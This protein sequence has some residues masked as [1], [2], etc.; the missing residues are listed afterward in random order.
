MT[1]PHPLAG[2]ARD[3][4]VP[5]TMSSVH[6]QTPPMF[7]AVKI[8][9]ERLM[10]AAREGREV[11]RPARPV[12]VYDF[13]VWRDAADA[14]DARYSIA[15][16]KGTYVRSLVHDLVRAPGARLH[17]VAHHA[18]LLLLGSMQL[19]GSCTTWPAGLTHWTECVGVCII[20]CICC[21]AK[22]SG[23]ARTSESCEERAV[24]TSM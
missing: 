16:S 6:M 4:G 18:W 24:G 7:S 5:V 14:Q 15:C 13:R 9:G 22:R 1:A 10:H 20:E 21:R 19:L 3:S 23:L 11:E 17:V 8:R 2:S 12:C